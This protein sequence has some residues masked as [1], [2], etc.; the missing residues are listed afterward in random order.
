MS[1][2]TFCVRGGGRGWSAD[3]G[4]HVTLFGKFGI[5]TAKTY[6]QKEF[7]ILCEGDSDKC[8]M[9][10]YK[11]YMVITVDKRM[12]DKL[13]EELEFKHKNP[14]YKIHAVLAGKSI[15]TNELAFSQLIF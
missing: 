6:Q 5:D 13:V 9:A 3:V 10:K 11:E 12:L 14:H 15:K 2:K 4:N 1:Y 7:L 8:G